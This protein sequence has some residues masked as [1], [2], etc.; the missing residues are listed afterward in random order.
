[1]ACYCITA[2]ALLYLALFM[3]HQRLHAQACLYGS[4]SLL[5]VWNMIEVTFAAA[6]TNMR[7][8]RIISTPLIVVATIAVV[9]LA[10]NV[11]RLQRLRAQRH[12]R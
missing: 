6:G 8:Y 12:E 11:T 10:V 3:A 9:W 4:L 1:M 2:P 5:F 7:E